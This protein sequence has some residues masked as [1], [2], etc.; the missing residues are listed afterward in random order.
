MLLL[1]KAKLSEC[2]LLEKQNFAFRKIMVSDQSVVIQDKAMQK[3]MIKRILYPVC[4]N[5][6]R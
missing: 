6:S 5:C 3:A 1:Q 2:F 4:I